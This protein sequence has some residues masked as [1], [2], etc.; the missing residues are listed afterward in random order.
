MDAADGTEGIRLA[1]KY[2]PDVI[3]SDVM[4]PGMDG[5]E[6]CRRV[7]GG[8]TDMP[9]PGDSADGLLAGRTAYPGL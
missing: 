5:V 8:V 2:V 3:I 4:M 7:E 1:M 6:C 9:Y